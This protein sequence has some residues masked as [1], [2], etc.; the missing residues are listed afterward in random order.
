MS[1]PIIVTVSSDI[2]DA[3]EYV[4][5]YMSSEKDVD[6]RICPLVC[7][8][9]LVCLLALGYA[10]IR[11][12]SKRV[13]HRHIEI[14]ADGERIDPLWETGGKNRDAV[15][16]QIS[17]CLLE[18]Y[19]DYYSLQYR[20]GVN[21]CKVYAGKKSIVDL[22]SE[23]YDFYNDSDPENQPKPMAVLWHIARGHRR[24]LFLA[25]S[26]L[27]I[28]HLGAL[29]LPVFVAN[30]INEVTET[31]AFFT[32]SVMLNILMSLTSL[33]VNLVFYWLDSRGYRRF[34][35]A[36]EAGFRMALVQKLQVLSMNFYNSTQT[37]VILSKLISDVQFIQ[38][39][40]YDRFMEV[41]CLCEDVIFIIVVA[42]K[43]YPPM[44]AFYILI[45]PA[46][47]F[48]LYRFSGPL[49]EKRSLMRQQNE[50]V[51]AA[52]KEMLVM[53]DLTRSH[54]LEKAEYQTILKKVREAQRASVTYDKKTVGIN[55]VTF[56]GFQGLRL[57]SLSIA[58][59]L[60]A[61][62]H[63][64]V[65]TL[66]LFQSVFDLI[67]N[68]VQRLLDSVP[69]ITQGYDSL[70][71]VNEILY[72]RDIE[73]NGNK[74]LPGP[75]K[76]EI[77]FR[78]V[79]FGYKPDRTP[80]LNNISFK[81]PAGGSAAFIG[82]SGEGKSTILKLILGLYSAGDGEILIDNVNLDTLEKS[83]YRRGIAVVPQNTVLFSGT[84]WDNLVYGLRYVT[85]DRV[86]EVIR[87]VGLQ[88]M[89]DQLPDG[90]NSP[91]LENGSNLS[92][93]QRQRIS[94]ARALLRDPK[95][96]LL[97]EAT[98]ALD[99]RS[100]RQ[101]QEAIDVMMGSCTVILVA[102]RL[103]TLRHADTIYRI[104]DGKLERYDNVE[105]AIRDMEGGGEA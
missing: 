35:R 44:L 24:F 68:N 67:I 43:T 14:R 3:V 6:A 29:L 55:N 36:V 33:T 32:R 37:G 95:I 18:Q 92:G 64:E 10:E 74:R 62:G 27:L 9:L 96:V 12:E 66:V 86:M 61:G 39:L 40:I 48:V 88:D 22:T 30:I 72:A 45:V 5:Q 65:G 54:G 82:K 75:M 50:Q 104:E 80:V 79:S 34:T 13:P 19:Q 91:L 69:L 46:V 93:G 103:S 77:E 73:H 60:T 57:L 105:R 70:C 53:E 21:V 89:L 47:T 31:G 58:A 41:L 20:K 4:E 11:V 51:N 23:I 63:I 38:M 97:D 78:N 99:N 56:G 94:I 84:L 7:E 15:E 102:H 90:L 2:R 49:K 81:V 101:V 28:K 26:V 42:V 25:I 52:V 76:G 16:K 100:E 71:S 59:F 83:A 98:S 1:N 8:E 87:R 17:S 85:T